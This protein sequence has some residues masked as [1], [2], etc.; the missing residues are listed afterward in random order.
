MKRSV[1]L[2]GGA[3]GSS[4]HYWC[5]PSRA[6]CKD[7][8][9][10]GGA[11]EWQVPELAMWTAWWHAGAHSTTWQRALPHGDM[12]QWYIV[13]GM[14]SQVT[15]RAKASRSDRISKITEVAKGKAQPSPLQ[16]LFTIARDREG[17]KG[18]PDHRRGEQLATC[19]SRKLQ[20][21]WRQGTHEGRAH[22]ATL[23][24]MPA[25]VR[26]LAKTCREEPEWLAT[27]RQQGT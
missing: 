2:R 4:C 24:C 23:A 3:S 9:L 18:A 6:E 16:A 8:A 21:D 12:V 11:S 25:Q 7:R 26:K 27:A 14:H 13:V 15:C 5:Q 22:P 20:E 17:W 19:T 1:A 10:N